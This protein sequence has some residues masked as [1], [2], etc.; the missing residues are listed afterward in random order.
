MAE[1]ANTSTFMKLPTNEPVAMG[2]MTPAQINVELEK[3]YAD[4][5]AG[6]H[7]SLKDV[8]ADTERDYGL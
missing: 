4:A 7:R 8:V 2:V 6:R 5:L 3:G 1:V